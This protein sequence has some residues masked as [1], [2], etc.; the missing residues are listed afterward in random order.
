LSRP[1]WTVAYVGLSAR[2]QGGKA[3]LA[4][5]PKGGREIFETLLEVNSA[6]LMMT[7]CTSGWDGRA[8]V[9]VRGAISKVGSSVKLK[10]GCVVRSMQV[11]KTGC[12][13]P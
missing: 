8:Q 1:N 13:C 6:S 4:Y 10:L 5:S 2:V 3:I 12:Y 9:G 11:R 7:S